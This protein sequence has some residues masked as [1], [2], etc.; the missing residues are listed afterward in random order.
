MQSRILICV[1]AVIVA[2]G[3][4]GCACPACCSKASAKQEQGT[5]QIS[6][7]EVPAPARTMIDILTSGGKIMKLEKE[8]EGGKVMYDIEGVVRGQYVEFD[9]AED[10]VVMTAQ[11][12]IKF[13]MLPC[14]VKTACIDYFGSEKGLQASREVE[15]GKIFYEVE[16]NKD[17][18]PVALK[19][20]DA[21]KIVE[22][23]K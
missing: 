5:D 14:P 20:D 9:I 1:L 8:E 23:E 19:L 13:N 21:G 12:S 10:G 15:E 2:A 7:C 11:Q 3:I 16:G 17:S 22:E 18:K 6:L 4:S